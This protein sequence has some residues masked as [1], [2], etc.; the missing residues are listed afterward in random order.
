MMLDILDESG[1]IYVS[2][3]TYDQC[4]SLN[5]RWEG[6]H[7]NFYKHFYRDQEHRKIPGFM[8]ALKLFV[9]KSPDPIRM[10]APF[11]VLLEKNTGIDWESITYVEMLGFIHVMSQQ[12]DFYALSVVPQEV[13]ASVS[14][15]TVALKLYEESWE[16]IC[17]TL[18]DK[19]VI[20]YRQ[21]APVQQV[22]MQAPVQ[23]IVQPTPVTPVPPAP[24]PVAPVA[25]APVATAVKLA[26]EPKI[27]YAAMAAKAKE[28]TKVQMAEKAKKEAASK[29]AEP[30][31][32]VQAAKQTAFGSVPEQVHKEE[33]NAVLD[34]YDGL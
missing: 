19:T 22:V 4:V 26:E 17:E 20:D 32:P 23:Q 14:T 3:N 8:S 7:N 29:P 2:K 24:T 16:E 27:D 25:P 18:K 11:F 15:P 9:D 28:M 6:D 10:L 1:V 30:K 33:S 31:K 13:R 21:M 34:M 12:L 5:T